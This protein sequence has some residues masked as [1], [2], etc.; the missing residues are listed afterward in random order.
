MSEIEQA[1]EILKV[2]SKRFCDG[3]EY[4]DSGTCRVNFSKCETAY[5]KAIQAL[6]KQ[7]PLHPIIK[8][9]HRG[10]FQQ[11]ACKECGNIDVKDH[12]YVEK[13]YAICP[14]CNKSIDGIFRN[15]CDNCGQKIDWSSENE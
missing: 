15:Y 10:G 14:C 3:C 1:V 5:D 4:E 11:F 12:T 2:V 13:D 9:R 7:I 6:Q 8:E